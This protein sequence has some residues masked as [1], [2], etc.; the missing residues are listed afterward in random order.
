MRKINFKCFYIL[1][2]LIGYRGFSQN[3]S[4]FNSIEKAQNFYKIGN[5]EELK[6]TLNNCVFS[7]KKSSNANKNYARELMGLT[8]IAED[9]ITLANDYI[10]QIILADNKFEPITGNRNFVFRELYKTLYDQNVGATISSLSKRPED[11]RTAPAS[12]ELIDAEQ[13]IERGYNDIVELLAD[14]AGF[15]ISKIHSVLFANI[16]QLGFRQENTERT[17]LMVDGVEENDLWLNWAYLSRQYPLSNIKA[18]EVIY[19]PASTVYGPRAFVGTIN[20]ITYSGTEKPG[21]F[22]KDKKDSESGLYAY[23]SIGSGS[24]NTKDA[25]FTIGSTKGKF[26]FQLTGRYFSS[27]EHD[28][29][30]E[31]FYNYSSSDLDKFDYDHLNLDFS[32]ADDLNSYLVANNL[33]ELSSLYNV[34]NN[35]IILTDEGQNLALLKDKNAYSGIVNGNPI[36]YSNHTEDYFIGGKISINNFLFGFRTWKR[37][38]GFNFYQDV[39]VASSKSGS[40]WSPENITLY[41]NFNEQLNENLSYS[42]LSTFKNHRLGKESNRVNF[43]P[44]GDPRTSLSIASLVDES[45]AT[46][47]GWRNRFY[48]YQALQGRTEARM[49]YNSDKLNLLYGVDFRIKST[50][51]DY[52]VH[53]NYDTDLGTEDEYASYIEE[54]FAQKLGTVSGQDEGSNMFLVRDL[55]NYIQGSYVLGER[56]YLSGGIRYD[57][58]RVRLNEGYEVFTPRLGLLYNAQ[59]FTVK[60]NYSTGFQDVSLYTKYSTGGGRTP[61]PDIVPEQVNYIDLVLLGNNTEKTFKWNLTGFSYVVSNAVASVSDGSLVYNANDGNY[62]VLGSMLNLRYKLKDFN[63]Y[64]NATYFN[65]Y[66]ISTEEFNLVDILSVDPTER[67][68]LG[69]IANYRFNAGVFKR[70]KIKNLNI[71]INGRVNW[72]NTRPVGPNTTQNLNLGVN[73]TDEIP[74]YFVLNGNFILG[75]SRFPM[76]KLSISWDNILNQKYYHPGPRT[77]AGYFDLENRRGTAD[78]SSFISSSLWNKNVPYVPQRPTY[79]IFKLIIDL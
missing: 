58:H 76:A 18:V 40:V 74:S 79:L 17:L 24:F 16:F 32:N 9:S 54:P 48:F 47:H 57:I 28:M 1:F 33:S 53:M 49:Y 10:K 75:H 51:G 3:N 20:I 35:S 46:T 36:S 64:A 15:E 69:D 29:S 71:G 62:Y 55:G 41:I 34:E 70:I 22:F 14:I 39:D 44:F 43:K 56:F 37:T 52:L 27:D 26:N 6:N 31:E 67:V 42:L 7:N 60:L 45:L 4:C 66:K 5:F 8:A 38:E 13:I 25:D 63:F 50:Q 21:N 72:V 2:L 23:G 61:N 78:Y 11:I 65:P 68:R 73:E 77:A 59:N 30:S 12:L 19:G